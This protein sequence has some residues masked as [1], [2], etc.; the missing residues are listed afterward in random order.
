M[1]DFLQALVRHLRLPLLVVWDRLPAH[2]SRLVQDYIASLRRLDFHGLS[3]TLRA[4]I[5]PGR[6]HLGLLEAARVAEC[7][8]RG[9][10]ATD[11]S[12]ATNA[13]SHAPSSAFDHRLLAASFFVARMTLYYAGL[14]SSVTQH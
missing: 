14:N 1:L 5:E 3:A 9:L 13:T 2:R 7:L 10:L 6:I 12:C 11:R 8:S 4:G